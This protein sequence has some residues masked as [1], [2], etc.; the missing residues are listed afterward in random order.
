M[1]IRRCEKGLNNMMLEEVLKDA[2]TVATKRLLNSW[3]KGTI[4]CPNIHMYS[5]HVPLLKVQGVGAADK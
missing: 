4:L 5:L 1:V 3:V 2:V